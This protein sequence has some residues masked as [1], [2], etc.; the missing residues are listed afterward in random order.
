MSSPARYVQNLDQILTRSEGSFFNN[1]FRAKQRFYNQLIRD[2]QAQT[3]TTEAGVIDQEA[4][5]E[6]INTLLELTET[7]YRKVS[8]LVT[9]ATGLFLV[10][11]LGNAF[12]SS[13]LL[14]RDF[15]QEAANYVAIDGLNKATS[16]A[17][18]LIK[19]YRR[20]I[21]NGIRDGLGVRDIARN[22]R[23]EMPDLQ[24]ARSETIARTETLMAM[25]HAKEITEE[26]VRNALTGNLASVWITAGDERVRDSHAV[27]NA[28]Y[29]GSGET[30]DVGGYPAQAP[31]TTGNASEDINCRCQRLV[32][33]VEEAERRGYRRA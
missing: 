24:K 30:F 20:V 2:Y 21:T 8:P 27:L 7:Q 29:V 19:D 26:P 11:S 18:T 5:E 32:M 25:D 4:L 10:G 9:N 3:D 23:A 14:S 17:D 22:L 13:I 33:T 15:T 12:R 28:T 1:V 16:I 6:H 31:R